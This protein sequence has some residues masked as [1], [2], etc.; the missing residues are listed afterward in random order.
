VARRDDT[1]TIETVHDGAGADL[2]RMLDAMPLGIVLLDGD[3]KVQIVNRAYR[4]MFGAG[5][6]EFS[7]G[8]DARDLLEAAR[9]RGSYDVDEAEWEGYVATRLKEIRRGDIEPREMRRANGLTL[10][11]SVVSLSASRRLITY[12]DR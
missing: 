7:P 2:A 1:T 5:D 9:R 3:L 10:L 6:D 11:S 12:Y 8:S 4:R